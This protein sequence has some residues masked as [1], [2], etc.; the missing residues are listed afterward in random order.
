MDPTVGQLLTPQ[1]FNLTSSYAM[2]HVTRRFILGLPTRPVIVH[3][4]PFSQGL[5]ASDLLREKELC[6]S[7]APTLH[8]ARGACVPACT[9]YTPRY[10]NFITEPL[11]IQP[12]CN[13]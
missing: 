12:S 10:L 5:T 8:G 11:N 6:M 3:V 13:E 1:L 4:L 9:V 7:Y 2:H